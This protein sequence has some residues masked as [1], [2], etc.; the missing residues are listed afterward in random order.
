M[1]FTFEKHTIEFSISSRTGY[2]KAKASSYSKGL[3]SIS[4][5]FTS[6]A[7]DELSAY[8]MISEVRERLNFVEK[9]RESGLDTDDTDFSTE[10]DPAVITK[11]GIKFYDLL[12]GNLVDACS[13]DTL[14]VVG[15]K[16][17]EFLI[18]K[19]EEIDL[20]LQVWKN[21]HFPTKK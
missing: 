14:L 11:E 17:L 9:V 10:V 7:S 21:K 5:Y 13:L 18:V 6:L 1:K 20:T 8:A 16:W 4:S 15:E 3:S 12:S 19:K 2:P